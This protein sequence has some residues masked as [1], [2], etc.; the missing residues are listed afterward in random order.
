MPKKIENSKTTSAKEK[1]VSKANKSVAAQ[2][3]SV[4][5]IDTY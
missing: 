5:M 4:D 2:K 1:V 3:I